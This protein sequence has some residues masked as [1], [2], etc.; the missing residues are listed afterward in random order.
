MKCWRFTKELSLVKV[1]L[2]KKNCELC[3][4]KTSIVG[5]DNAKEALE[6]TYHV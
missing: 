6:K 4:A 5:L 2:E 1:T 3:Y